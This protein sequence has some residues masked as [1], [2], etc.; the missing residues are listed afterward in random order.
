MPLICAGSTVSRSVM[1]IAIVM[2]VVWAILSKQRT[3]AIV[4]AVIL[5]AIGYAAIDYFGLMSKTQE[6]LTTTQRRHQMV[7]DSPW[8]RI[9]GRLSPSRKR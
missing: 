2:L 1:L 7:G 8:L 6:I 3:R 4:S 9:V 5:I